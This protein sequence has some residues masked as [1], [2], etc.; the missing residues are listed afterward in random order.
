MPATICLWKNMNRSSGGT[1][2][3]RLNEGMLQRIAAEGHGQYVRATSQDAGIQ[4]LMDELR[5]MD[6][7]ET[8]TYRYAGHED[9]YRFFLAIGI[10]M[11]LLSIVM[12]ERRPSGSPWLKINLGTGS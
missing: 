4:P 3:S 1:V 11:I 5:K 2:I 7:S 9:R 6:Q 12:S 10:I 8:G